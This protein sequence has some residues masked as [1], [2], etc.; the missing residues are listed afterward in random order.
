MSPSSMLAERNDVPKVTNNNNNTATTVQPSQPSS[1]VAVGR[2]ISV[3]M[4]QSTGVSGTAGMRTA[5]F[6]A[7]LGQ[8]AAA[9]SVTANKTIAVMPISHSTSNT[10][11]IVDSQPVIKK[12]KM[13]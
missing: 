12:I 10:S 3:T 4:A 8:V 9:G 5:P 7:K 13:G 1:G 6:A 11:A 2:V